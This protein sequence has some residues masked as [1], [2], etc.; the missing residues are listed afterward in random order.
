LTALLWVATP[1][2]S[3]LQAPLDVLV[4]R[5]STAHSLGLVVGQAVWAAAMLALCWYVQRRAE[6]KLVIQ[7]G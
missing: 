1:F 5:G 4:E 3:M 7:G 6:R 2:P